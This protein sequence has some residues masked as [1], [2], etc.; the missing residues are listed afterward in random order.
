MCPLRP[1]SFCVLSELSGYKLPPDNTKIMATH[2]RTYTSYAMRYGI[3]IL[4]II[5]I[6]SCKKKTQTYIVPDAE[7]SAY[8]NA[9][10]SGEISK[11]GAVMVR[12]ND[13]AVG[14]NRV[15]TPLSNGV[16]RLSPNIA[17]TA[18][19]QDERT[20]KFTPSDDFK[21]GENYVVGVRLDKIFDKVPGELKDFEFNFRTREQHLRVNFEGIRAPDPSDLSQQETTTIYDFYT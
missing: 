4:L 12:F 21:S 7:F 3:A 13:A 5:N 20:I 10:T 9:Y 6:L 15:G 17:G 16:F 1:I 19:W 18:E 2:T 8:V 11:T 14:S